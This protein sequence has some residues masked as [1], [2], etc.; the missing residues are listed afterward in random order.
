MIVVTTRRF[1]QHTAHDIQIVHHPIFPAAITNGKQG[2][3]I[4]L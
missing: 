2:F 3:H 1:R 4:P